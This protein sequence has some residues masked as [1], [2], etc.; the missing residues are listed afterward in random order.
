MQVDELRPMRE[1]IVYTLNPTTD[2]IQGSDIVWN[3]DFRDPLIY[4]DSKYEPVE[5]QRRKDESVRN[6]R[7]ASTVRLTSMQGR[8]YT[9]EVEME[10]IEVNG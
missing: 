9:P 5:W 1:C 2:W 8:W 10:E 7:R 4:P 6:H 3:G